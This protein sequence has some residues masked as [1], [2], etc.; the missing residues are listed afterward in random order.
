MPSFYTQ[1]D[2]RIRV[3][4]G[5]HTA[6]IYAIRQ[7]IAKALVAY[8]QKCTC[9]CVRWLPAMLEFYV[10]TACA[11]V[12]SIAINRRRRSLE[13]GDQGHPPRVRPHPPRGR[14]ASQG[15][16]EVRWSLGPRSFPEVVPLDGISIPVVLARVVRLSAAI[17]VMHVAAAGVA[18][19]WA[20]SVASSRCCRW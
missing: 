18:R 13:E 8:Y 10:L 2:I 9:R 7:A 17:V 6:Q 16:E 14:P 20:S 19:S 4:G 15:S 11:F 3:K 5:G 1:V 12:F